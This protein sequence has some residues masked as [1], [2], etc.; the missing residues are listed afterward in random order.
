M[1]A[2]AALAM[3]AVAALA[4]AAVAALAMT[5]PGPW[6]RPQSPGGPGDADAG[7]QVFEANCAMCHGPDATGMMGMHPSLRGAVQRLSL[8]GTYVTIR[9]GRATRPP[10]PA[11]EGR[12]SDEQIDDVV[13]YIASLA[14]GPRNFGPDQP[15]AGGDRMMEEG[16]TMD[17]GMMDDRLMGG[18]LALWALGTLLVAAGAAATAWLVV[19]RRRTPVPDPEGDTRARR[20]LDRRYASGELSRDDY[21]QRRADLE[22]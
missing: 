6:A 4:M 11:F 22:R 17:D 20:E 1:T 16:P 8:E 5:G 14:P 3:T 13:A 7:Q 15:A 18:W 2:V 10:M 19:S 9:N 21:L 12:L